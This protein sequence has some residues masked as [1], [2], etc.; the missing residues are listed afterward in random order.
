ML[1]L[2]AQ[3]SDCLAGYAAARAG[4]LAERPALAFTF[5]SVLDPSA[6]PVGEA[7]VWANAFVA[8]RLG[9]GGSWDEAAPELAR[10]VW[11]TAGA[12]LGTPLAPLVRRQVVTTPAVLAARTG[13]EN[14]GNHLAP[15]LDQSLGWRPVRALGGHRT[16]WPGRYLGGAGTHPGGSVSG[17]PGRLA[18]RAVLADLAVSRSDRLR[19]AGRDVAAQLTRTWGVVRAGRSRG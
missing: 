3:P 17:E 2:A 19:T 11:A 14:P 15:T 18:A 1:W 4:T 6:A 10:R 8:Q 5:P 12:C 7:T 9:D 13:A 16:P